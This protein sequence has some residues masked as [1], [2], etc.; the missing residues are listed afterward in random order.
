MRAHWY[1]SVTALLTVCAAP[2]A[3]VDVL[4]CGNSLVRAG[5]TAGEVVAKCGAP[6]AKEVI[7]VPIRVRRPN[8]TTGVVGTTYIERWTYER[9]S[10]QFPALLTF[11]EG[12]LE[13]I[14]LLTGR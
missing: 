13:R 10:G 14:E 4:R 6:S 11:E 1:A 7:P 3:A 2:A 5:M 9:G 8:G 12:G